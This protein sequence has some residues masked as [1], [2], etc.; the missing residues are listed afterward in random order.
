MA[1][2]EEYQHAIKKF[3]RIADSVVMANAYRLAGVT[4]LPYPIDE[5]MVYVEAETKGYGNYGGELKKILPQDIL[6]DIPMLYSQ[7]EK[8]QFWE[9]DKIMISEPDID[10]PILHKMYIIGTTKL[11]KKHRPLKRFWYK[12]TMFIRAGAWRM[13]IFRGNLENILGLDKYSL[14]PLSPY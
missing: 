7:I 4:S 14:A 11:I 3:G 10:D 13:Y 5:V 2:E 12:N 8:F 9:W 1:T 6:K